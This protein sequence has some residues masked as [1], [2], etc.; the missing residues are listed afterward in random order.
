MLLS[1][2]ISCRLVIYIMN[3]SLSMRKHKHGSKVLNFGPRPCTSPHQTKPLPAE[4]GE[5]R[6]KRIGKRGEKEKEE[7]KT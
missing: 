4:R 5:R 6:E 7:E 3:Y 2:K 1:Q